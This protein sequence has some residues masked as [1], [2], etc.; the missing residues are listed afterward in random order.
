MLKDVF[1]VPQRG[2][3]HVLVYF[4]MLHQA[5]PL[6][7]MAFSMS[8][9]PWVPKRACNMLIFIPEGPMKPLNNI[10]QQLRNTQTAKSSYAASRN[11]IID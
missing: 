2:N 6:C 11:W 10:F 4:L 8:Q 9:I 1:Q 5:E 7:C 3:F